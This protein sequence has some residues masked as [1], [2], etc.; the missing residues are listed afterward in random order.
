M[1]VPGA[2]GLTSF[3]PPAVISSV[4]RA[5]YI[6]WCQ[7]WQG[8]YNEFNAGET[9]SDGNVVTGHTCEDINE[10]LNESDYECVLNSKCTNK[11]GTYACTCDEF[12]AEGDL[13]PATGRPLE[14]VD[15]NECAPGRNSCGAGAV[16]TDIV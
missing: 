5:Y 13:D 1:P 11:N 6:Y 8:N 15:D 12:F 10:C 2:A 9:D 3:D 4:E 14:C 7:S 16:C